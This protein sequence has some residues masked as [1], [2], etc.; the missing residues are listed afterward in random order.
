VSTSNRA[1]CCRRHAAEGEPVLGRWALCTSHCTCGSLLGDARRR[2][3]L[4]WCCARVGESPDT[5]RYPG[6]GASATSVSVTW[7]RVSSTCQSR[8]K[9]AKSFSFFLYLR[10]FPHA[11][12]VRLT[13]GGVGAR[14]YLCFGSLLC[15][16]SI[17]DLD[18]IPPLWVVL[19]CL[20]PVRRFPLAAW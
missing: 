9:R 16:A 5:R 6:S 17:A 8:F 19:P 4:R 10:P 7:A 11:F 18:W 3:T 2:Y 12:V 15:L 14:M 1:S 20:P 13:C